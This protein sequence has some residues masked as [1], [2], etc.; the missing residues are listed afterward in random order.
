MAFGIRLMIVSGAHHCVKISS[1][2]DPPM[3]DLARLV[4]RVVRWC[5]CVSGFGCVAALASG[6][7]GETA[8]AELSSRELVNPPVC[9]AATA[10][11]P[12]L[13]G[14]CEVT[15]LGANR[16][17]IKVNLTAK[18]APVEVGGYK[19]ETENYNGVYLSPVVQAMAGDTVA[20]HLQNELPKPR[21]VGHHRELALAS[22]ANPTNLHYFH[23]GIVTPNNSRPPVDAGKGD[24]DNIYVNLENGTDA[25]GKAASFDYNVPIPGD[26][27]LDAGVLEG[28]DGIAHPPGLNWYHSH[29]HGVSSDQVMGGLSGLLSI[30]DDKAN[31]RAKCKKDGDP[32]R[33]ARTQRNSKTRPTCVTCCC[34]TFR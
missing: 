17:K 25:S 20:A 6:L 7:L 19:V 32:T 9:S 5:G 13:K 27:E 18:L 11:Q 14:I 31:V 22:G 30:G 2:F 23:G 33:A 3:R 15:A 24:G 10:S 21:A 1:A 4:D 8:R 26:G 34:A 29:L 28:K 16:N 12:A